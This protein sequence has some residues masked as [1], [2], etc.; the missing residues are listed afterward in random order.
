MATRSPA[1]RPVSTP[2][3]RFTL[4]AQIRAAIV[5]RGLSAYQLAKM[6]G[7]NATVAGRFMSGARDIRL[8]TADR[9]CRAL[10]LRL[11][12]TGGAGGGRPRPPRPVSTPA[13]EGPEAYLERSSGRVLGLGLDPCPVFLDPLAARARIAEGPAVGQL[14]SI[15]GFGPVDAALALARPDLFRVGPAPSWWRPEP[16]PPAG[17]PAPRPRRECYSPGLVIEQET[18]AALFGLGAGSWK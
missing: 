16:E 9:L 14:A 4:S 3:D 17:A 5:A 15:A 1:R 2:P 13:P 8:E 18:A 12:E 10:R 7:V 11:V 6:A